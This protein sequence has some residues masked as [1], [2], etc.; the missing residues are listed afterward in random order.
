MRV[1]EIRGA[2]GLEH[3]K[4]G[5]RPDLVPGAGQVVVRIEA[6]SVN[7]RDFVVARRGY[8]RRTGKLPLVPVSDGAG[9]VVA[10]GPGVTRASVGDHGPVSGYS[11]F[12]QVAEHSRQGR[13]MR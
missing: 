12:R 10:T 6:A 5:T 13:R 4:P 1:M 3:L 11:A 9:V 2:W 7:Y 8:G